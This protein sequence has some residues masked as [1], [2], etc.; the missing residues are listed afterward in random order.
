MRKLQYGCVLL[1]LFLVGFPLAVQAQVTT[2][3]VRGTVTDEQGAAVADATVTITNTDTGL[4]RTVQSAGDGAFTFP[5]LPIGPYRLRATRTGFKAVDQ[6]GIVLHVNDNL[7]FNIALKIGAVSETVTVEAS[8]IQIQT[9]DR[10]S[11]RLNS[12]HPSI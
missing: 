2:A 1:V 5:D 10:K 7:T 11:T 12:S 9:T 3:S 4:S 8:P 6:T